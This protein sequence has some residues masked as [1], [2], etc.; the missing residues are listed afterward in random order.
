MSSFVERN[1]VLDLQ[2]A[3]LTQRGDGVARHD[4]FAVFVPGALPGE[5][6]RA[7]VTEVR[8]SYAR[9]ALQEIVQPALARTVA[10]CTIA[11]IC[12]GC[13][14]QHLSR[15]G[16]LR[17][18]RQ[19]VVDALTRIGKLDADEVEAR[20]TATAEVADQWNYRDK[21]TYRVDMTD[22]RGVGGFVCAGTHEIVAAPD[23]L[24]ARPA[25]SRLLAC[26]LAA[27]DAAGKSDRA[28][29]ET[30][31][32][33]VVRIHD[34]G[35]LVIF[36]ARDAVDA[37]GAWARV[38]ARVLAM[39]DGTSA[40]VTGIALMAPSDLRP[41]NAGSTPSHSEAYA[42]D[43]VE[44]GSLVPLWGS[45]ALF[46]E[47][48]GLRLRVSATAFAQVNRAVAVEICRR[49]LAAAHLQ[50]GDTVFD[51]YCGVGAMAILAAGQ[52]RVIYGIETN[53]AAIEDARVNAEH[54]GAKDIALL[55]ALAEEELPRLQ[56]VGIRP[57]VVFLDP[58]RA[59][60]E[61]SVLE[62]ILATQPRTVVYISCDP[63]T[64]ARDIRVL[65]EGG[66][67]LVDATPLDAFP[68]TGH[69]ECVVGLVRAS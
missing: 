11:G 27:V 41:S 44:A 10:P 66:Y 54:A 67:R 1:A 45:T 15:T 18:K 25:H 52:G 7:R 36:V 16:Q 26:V 9:A 33:V 12:G 63:A 51:V 8:K 47:V 2:V 34:G 64:L 23:C 48:L 21:V 57:D 61:R 29:L 38:A 14:L 43:E 69:V 62:V 13:A 65:V 35:A 39:A 5:T 37:A 56:A 30:L 68:Q 20:V 4:G 40:P 17:W 60:C 55:C 31:A 28:E 19:F 22:G 6:V 46:Y 24:I 58:P 50:P 49:A 42:L 53:Q 32:K 3:G 59:G